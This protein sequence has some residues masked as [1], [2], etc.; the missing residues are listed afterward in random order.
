MNTSVVSQ[1]QANPGFL[2]NASLLKQIVDTLYDKM[3]ADYRINRFFF[4]RPAADQSAALQRFLV[5]VL[6]SKSTA[7]ESLSL[8]DDYFTVAFARTNAKPALVT[9]RDFGF[10]LEIIGGRDIRPITLVCEAHSHLMKLLPEDFH[11]DVVMAHLADTL[12][13]LAIADDQSSR[14]LAFA[15][16]G[17]DGLL[18]RTEEMLKAA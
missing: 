16:S 15:E 11:Y 4:T 10:L 9:G 6:D 8:L 2:G 3:L 1:L 5:A 14:I 7:D 17:R 13:E 12:H 18:G